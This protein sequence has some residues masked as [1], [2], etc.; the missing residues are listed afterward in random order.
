MAMSV[1]V[2][3]RVGDAAGC[4]RGISGCLWQPYGRSGEGNFGSASPALHAVTDIHRQA[5]PVGFSLLAGSDQSK[6]QTPIWR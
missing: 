3:G 6:S 4:D 2:L 1:R 5:S